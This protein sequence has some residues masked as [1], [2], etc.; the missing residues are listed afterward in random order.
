MKKV[1]VAE[2]AGFCFGVARA[3]AAVEKEIAARVPGE[4]IYTLGR[5]IHNDTYNR[6]LEAEGV[7]VAS[8]EELEALAASATEASPV[9][10]F[11][12]AHGMTKAT[13]AVLID[14]QK[15]NPCFSFVDCTC[16]YVKKIH[17]IAKEQ[18]EETQKELSEGKEGR[19][20]IV[21][22]SASHPEVIGFLSRFEGKTFVFSTAEAMEQAFLNGEFHDCYAK[23]PILLAQTTQNLAEWEKIKKVVK[24]DFKNPL[25]FDTIGSVTESLQ[26]EAADLAHECDFMVVIGGRDSSNSAKLYTIC[27]SI[28][29][30][31]VWIEQAED[32]QNKIPFSCHQA[33]VVAGASTPHDIIEEVSNKMSEQILNE[34][35]AEMLEE[36]LKTLNTG[37]TV[38]GIITAINAGEI[39]LDLGAKVT[40]V[41]KQ[42]QI[43]DDPSASLEEMFKIGDEVEAFVIR[44]S[45]VEGFAELSKKRVDSDKNWQKVVEACETKETV[46]GKVVAANKGGVEVVVYNNK[47][48]VPA[49]FT[50]IP[51]GEDFAVLVGQTVSL[52]VIEIKEGKKAKG[53]ISAVL[54]DERRAREKAF[55]ETIEE[56]MVFTG[57]VKSLTSYG[58]FV[59]L[60]GVDGM[61]HASELTWKRVSDP[62]KVVSVGDE[63][64]VY[65]KKLNVEDKRISLS[66]KTAETNPWYIFTNKYAV[67]DVASVKIVSLMPFGAFAEIVDNVDGL[68][69]ISQIAD[70][71]IAKPEDVLE[72]GQVV[73]VKII[74]IDNEKQKVSLS[75]RALIEEAKALAD[76]MVAEAEAAEAVEEVV[77]DAPA[78]DAE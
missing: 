74:D 38:V 60:G 45:D 31:T 8:T 61:V 19:F 41:I 49:R 12:R 70:H 15:R 1:I 40:G 47:V 67:G 68:I 27:K 50:G 71:K 14:C 39:Q 77:E 33:G 59:D 28:C 26:K 22:G 69:H 65:V 9:K 64:T 55:W 73:D 46:T 52:R 48:F 43:T 10:L 32:L 18:W 62:S 23:Q 53:S 17:R 24:K 5:L 21:L 13:E 6:R 75:I 30:D 2:N 76:A 25:I 16:S 54:A 78:A 56:G 63:L 44:V 3:T 4:R 51:R 57:K 66:C 34:N 7:R 58:A 72:V 37:D 35:F 20:L 29:A 36:S 42:A 11:V